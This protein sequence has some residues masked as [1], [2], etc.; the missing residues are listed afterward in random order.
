MGFY[1]EYKTLKDETA[2]RI[3]QFCIRY[4]GSEYDVIDDIRAKITFRKDY[5]YQ[6]E[7]AKK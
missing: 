5:R 4:G 3:E 7:R 6:M 1:E 2:E